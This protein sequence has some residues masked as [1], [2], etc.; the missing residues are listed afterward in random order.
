VD[1]VIIVKAANVVWMAVWIV[2]WIVVWITRDSKLLSRSAAR[3]VRVL[4]P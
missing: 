4:S 3:S 2:V 1:L